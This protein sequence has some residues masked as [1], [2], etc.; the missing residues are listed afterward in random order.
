MCAKCVMIDKHDLCV[1]KSVAKPL[2]KTVASESNKKPRNNV[3][4]LHE[5]FGKI[6][7]WSYIK[8]TPSGYIWKRKSPTGNVNPNVSMPLGNTSRTANVKDTMTSRRS[9]VSNT[10]LSSNSFAAHRDCSIHRAVTIKRVYYVEGLN[11]NLFSVGQ[12][13]DADLEV[14]FRKSTCFIRDLKGNGLFT[15]SRGTDLYSITL[16]RTNSPNLICLM[17][18][19]TLSQA[20]LWHRRLSHLNFDTINLLSKNDIVVGLPKLKFVKDHLCSSCELGKAKRKSFHTK[21]TPRVIPTTSVSRLQLKSNPVGDRVLR[22]NSRGKKLEVEEHRRNVKLPKNKMFVTA[23]NDSL[24]AKTLNVKSVSAICDNRTEFK[25]SEMNQFCQMKGIK[26]EFSVARTPQ[27]NGVAERKNKTLIEAAR[28]MLADSLDGENLD[29]MKEKG[30][31]CIFMGYST[32]MALEHDSLSPGPQRQANVPQADMRV[33]TLN[34]LDLLF[35]LMFDELPNGS[36][37]VVSKSFVKMIKLQMMSLSTSFLPR[38]KTMGRLRHVDSSNMQTFYQRYPS[39]HRWTKDHPLEQVIGNPLQSVRTRRQLESNAEMCMFTLTMSRTESKNIKEAMA[40]S[41][42]IKSM[43]E[44]LHQFDRLDVWELVDRPLCT[45]VINLKWL[46]KNKR[47]EE[48]IVIRS[49]SRLVAK[50]CAQKEGVDFEESSAPVAWLEAVRLF[51][52]IGTP[53]ATKHLAADLRGTPVD[54]TKYRSKSTSGGIQ[55]LGG[56]K[57]V[58]WSLKKQDCTSMS[59]AEAEYVSLFACCAQVLWMRTQLTDYGFYLDKVHMYCD[60]KAAIASRAILSSIRVPS[61]SMLVY[62]FIKEKVEKGIVELFFVRTEYQLADLFTKALPEER[63]KYLIRRLEHPSDE[64]IHSEDG[65]LAGA[66]VK[67]ALGRYIV[68]VAASFQLSRIHIPQ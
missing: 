13:Y 23:C 50:G 58:S 66:N 61:T 6:Y 18:K 54:Q 62:H 25:N 8:F 2:K 67:Q 10:P 55:F 52:G 39:E 32:Q 38:S 12:F 40:D 51:I 44:E 36:S 64:S 60:S 47:D 7:K 9:I 16:Q 45:N 17:A 59:F 31:E 5:R 22:S 14:A 43:Q 1:P 63:F 48:N 65:N 11:H 28:T 24:N 19:A 29:K 53:M 42:W 68:G 20:W 56:D 41:A 15:G 33:T 27:Q 26:I 57:L 4:K 30:D 21:L 37:K 49:K 3:R 34:E 35:S 46:W